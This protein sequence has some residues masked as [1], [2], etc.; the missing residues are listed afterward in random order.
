MNNIKLIKE[1]AKKYDESQLENTNERLTT[2]VTKHG[3]EAVSAA[4]GLKVSSLIQYTTKKS[5]P[6]VSE[7]TV[8]KAEKVLSQF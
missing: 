5:S 4:S 8:K 7:L 2:L 1:A 6:K 3:V